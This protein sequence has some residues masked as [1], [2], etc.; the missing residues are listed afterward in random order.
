M[1]KNETKIVYAGGTSLF[2]IVYA[3]IIIMNIAGVIDWPWL[4]VTAPFWIGFAIM[5][6]LLVAYVVLY[7]L[8]SVWDFFKSLFKGRK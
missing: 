3:A 6:V 4:W 5:G 2:T 7:V 8:A 1:S